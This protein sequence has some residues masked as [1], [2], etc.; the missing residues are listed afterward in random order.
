[1]DYIKYS[2]LLIG[3][4]IGAYISSH[5]KRQADLI[6]VEKKRT[7][8]YMSNISQQDSV[9]MQTA[10]HLGYRYQADNI[11]G[12]SGAII[13]KNDMIV[14]EGWD[15]TTAKSDPTAHAVIEAVKDASARLST[16]SLKGATLYTTHQPCTICLAVLYNVGVDRVYFSVPLE[17]ESSSKHIMQ[18]FEKHPSMR[19]IPEIALQVETLSSHLK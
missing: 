16:L 18:N 1:M 15:R 13:V 5:F 8:L 3:L 7:Q 12:P 9:F 11:N 6:A 17:D 10:V 14:G 4:F 2:M 19:M